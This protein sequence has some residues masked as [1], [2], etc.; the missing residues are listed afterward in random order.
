LSGACVSHPRRCVDVQVFGVKGP[1]TTVY[2]LTKYGLCAMC[3]VAGSCLD[4]PFVDIAAFAVW[5]RSRDVATGLLWW[6]CPLHKNVESFLPVSEVY[7]SSRWPVARRCR[8][9]ANVSSCHR[10]SHVPGVVAHARV[11]RLTLV[12]NRA[13]MACT[14]SSRCFRWPLCVLVQSACGC[15]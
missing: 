3:R 2:G 8:C 6:L 11:L 4:F 12:L 14:S 13:H 5:C 1:T 7:V 9:H 15:R 10:I